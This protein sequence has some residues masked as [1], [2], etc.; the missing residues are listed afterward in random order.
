MSIEFRPLRPRS[1][2]DRTTFLK[3][4]RLDSERFGFF[5]DGLPA[6]VDKLIAPFGQEPFGP[7]GRRLVVPKVVEFG[8]NSV[9]LA[10]K[11]A[12]KPDLPR[13]TFILSE[14]DFP[15]GGFPVVLFD[16]EHH[17]PREGN[18]FARSSTKRLTGKPSVD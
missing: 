13:E 1:E 18:L 15:L 11:R 5:L 17:N 12:D 4:E 16:A 8:E 7:R 6:E 3:G 14:K 2:H 10:D 9:T